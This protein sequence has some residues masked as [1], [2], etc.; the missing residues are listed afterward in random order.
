LDRIIEVVK[1]FNLLPSP[2]TVA[3]VI[4][5]VFPGLLKPAAEMASA[6][7]AGG[8]NVDLSLQPKKNLGEQLKYA[9]RRGIPFAVFAG[10]SETERGEAAIKDLS[11]GRQ[12]TVPIATLADEVRSAI[13]AQA[14]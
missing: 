6:L 8:L 1:E 14:Q 10:E 11:S 5:A 2:P 9:G 3:N 12:W 13:A 4:V 7:R